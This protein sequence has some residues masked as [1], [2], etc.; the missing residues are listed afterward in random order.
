MSFFKRIGKDLA[1]KLAGNNIILVE[2]EDLVHLQ[3]TLQN[4]KCEFK[5]KYNEDC[6]KGY[7]CPACTAKSLVA[8]YLKN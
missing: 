8:E 2:K 6:G 3:D 4:S 7:I 1:K 5:I